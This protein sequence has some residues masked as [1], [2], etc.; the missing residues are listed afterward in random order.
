[1]IGDVGVDLR[2]YIGLAYSG[3]IGIL[4]KIIPDSDH[5]L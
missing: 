5:G 3:Y 2:A 4:K 1:M